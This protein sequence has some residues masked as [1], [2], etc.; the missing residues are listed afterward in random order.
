MASI[1]FGGAPGEEENPEYLN[2]IAR[3]LSGNT[4]TYVNSV[5]DMNEELFEHDPVN[6]GS[7]IPSWKYD[8]LIFHTGLFPPQMCP[9][10]WAKSRSLR[11][12]Y[13]HY[14]RFAGTPVIVLAEKEVA[15]DIRNPDKE[16]GFLQ[17]DEPFNADEILPAVY[18]SIHRE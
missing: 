16:A 8:L 3:I 6:L 1:L 13:I 11:K 9:Q 18:S 4:V 14:L 17:F 2:L 5:L 10:M 12:P 7:P 15:E